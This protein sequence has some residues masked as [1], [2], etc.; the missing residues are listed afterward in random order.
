MLPWQRPREYW[1]VHE[2][3]TGPVPVPVDHLV[4][5][6]VTGTEPVDVPNHSDLSGHARCTH[7]SRQRQRCCCRHAG[8]AA[9]L[10]HRRAVHTCIGVVGIFL[11]SVLAAPDQCELWAASG[12]CET[13]PAFMRAACRRQCECA[14]WAADGECVQNAGWMLT[15][16]ERA[17]TRPPPAAAP[18]SP[19][20]G[21]A[22]R[23]G[24][25]ARH[26]HNGPRARD[27]ATHRRIAQR[28]KSIPTRSSL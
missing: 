2:R 10:M 9:S 28:S 20:G 16:C 12:E 3:S 14:R 18:A 5:H 25:H 26:A 24:A 7:C 22:E 17:C 21:A 13:N 8:R 4:G 23:R 11:T 19:H 27:V 1:L 15:H 6:Q